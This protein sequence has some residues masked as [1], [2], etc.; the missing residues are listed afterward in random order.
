[1][2]SLVVDL[3]ITTPRRATTST[4]RRTTRT[5]SHMRTYGYAERSF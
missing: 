5:R 3:Q 2:Y 1:M 4:R